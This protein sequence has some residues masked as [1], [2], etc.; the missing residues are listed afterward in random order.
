MR[1][2]RLIAFFTVALCLVSCSR[3]PKKVRQGQLERGNTYFDHGNDKA[4]SLM[5]RNAI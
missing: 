2:A 3:D 1:F 5:Y 4:A